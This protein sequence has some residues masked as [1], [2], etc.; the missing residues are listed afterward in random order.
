MSVLGAEQIVGYAVSSGSKIKWVLSLRIEKMSRWILW[1]LSRS[2]LP[3][4]AILTS[5]F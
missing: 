1:L 4:V 3:S 5:A 2:K